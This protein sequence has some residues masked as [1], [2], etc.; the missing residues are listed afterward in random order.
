MNITEAFLNKVKF[1]CKNIPRVEW[2]G[3]L[4]YNIDGT[5]KDP[6]NMVITPIEIFIRDIGKAASTAYEYDEKCLEF[7][8]KNDL[9]MAKH[10]MIHSHNTMN[11][12][13]SGVDIDELHENAM[14]HNIYLSLVVNNFM[15]MVAKVVFLGKGMKFVCPD[16]DGNEYNFEVEGVK[17]T[18]FLYD[19]KLLFPKDE[20]VVDDSFAETFE[21][22]KKE[23]AEKEKIEA[24]KKAKAD[25]A[26]KAQQ[27]H[28]QQHKGVSTIVPDYSARRGWGSEDFTKS[29]QR[30]F[31]FEN[32]NIRDIEP[33]DD[34]AQP[35]FFGHDQFFAFCL[36]GG[37][38]PD[39]GMQTWMEELLELLMR[40]DKE[41]TGEIVTD[42]VVSNFATYYATYY[43]T[44]LYGTD[45]EEFKD[46]MNEF[47]I[48]CEV[49]SQFYSW[50]IPMKTGLEL[51]L[52]KFSQLNLNQNGNTEV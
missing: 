23:I 31:R 46:T 19:C 26:L 43:E 44:E 24:E 14:N 10:G 38:E 39:F 45:E 12:F 13:F 18:L 4:F 51:I 37:S 34:E 36:N 21:E 33:E 27:V 47:I 8:E 20:V 41:K 52:T 28:A 35:D 2:S 11:V 42:M 7:V 30:S 1:L 29:S 50:L 6:E 48:F 5:I 49:Y 25:A 40:I 22:V 17:S 32:S 9:Y 15:D 16:E 3:M